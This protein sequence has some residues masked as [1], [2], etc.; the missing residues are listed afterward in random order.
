MNTKVNHI[1]A[2]CYTV[3][4]CVVADNYYICSDTTACTTRVINTIFP[5]WSI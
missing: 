1:C 4:S 3:G 5:C 2:L